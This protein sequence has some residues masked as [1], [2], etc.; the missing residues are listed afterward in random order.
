MVQAVMEGVAYSLAD[1]CECLAKTGV[2]INSLLITGGGAKS[3]VWAQM[4]ATILDK[5]IIRVSGKDAGPAF[6]AARLAM[7]GTNAA[8]FEDFI[9]KSDPQQDVLM[10]DRQYLEQYKQGLERFRRLYECTVEVF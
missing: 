5:K 3:R 7:V 2:E 8:G 6:G 4:I 10:P 1:G 9:F